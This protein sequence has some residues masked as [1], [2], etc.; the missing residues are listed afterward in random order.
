MTSYPQD[1][2]D[3]LDL[4]DRPIAFHRIFATVGGGA[5]EGLF[6]SQAWYWSKTK[7]AQER[8]GW[9]YHSHA[10]WE[11]ETAL[12]R[13]EQQTARKNLVKRGLLEE[14]LDVLP[15]EGRV[16]WYRINRDGL[17]KAISVPEGLHQT[18]GEVAPKRPTPP[19]QS[20][21]PIAPKRPTPLISA[22]TT[23]ETTGRE[24][25][26]TA[27]ASAL[28]SSARA[29]GVGV[30]GSRHSLE[31]RKAHAQRNNLGGGW[32]VR[33]ARGEFD[34]S[35][36]LDLER[37]DPA[38]VE[39]RRTTPR[40]SRMSL[41]AARDRLRSISRGP[42]PHNFD[43]EIGRMDLEPGVREQL[44]GEF[45]ALEP[46]GGGANAATAAAT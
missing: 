39:E 41:G 36:D 23:S 27:R 34:D 44:L 26:H 7:T 35:I 8:G 1:P 38:K 22:E 33:A 4:L 16:M 37:L 15:G 17:R 29:D 13:R 42:G 25:T 24:H 19:H 5:V 14:R 40:S 3:P 46:R 31:V 28:P 6:L 18:A 11:E 9:F 32:L 43:A 30:G 45:C 2:L 21:R 20:A 12:T 10:E